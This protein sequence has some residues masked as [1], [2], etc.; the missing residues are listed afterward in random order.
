MVYFKN[1]E[2]QV[3]FGWFSISVNKN[4]ILNIKKINANFY[5]SLIIKIKLKVKNKTNNLF[6]CFLIWLSHNRKSKNKCNELIFNFW[7]TSLETKNERT[8]GTRTVYICLCWHYTQNLY[9]NKF[10]LGGSFLILDWIFKHVV[11]YS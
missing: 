5:F 4:A 7:L 9:W 6:F 10:F 3:I 8:N 1:V 2:Y 11:W